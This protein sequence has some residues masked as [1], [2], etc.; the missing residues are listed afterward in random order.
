MDPNGASIG[1]ANVQITES[2]TGTVRSAETD[3][4]GSFNFTQVKP[5]VYSVVV[6]HDGF[7]KYQRDNVTVL[8]ASPTTVDVQLALGDIKETVTVESGAMPTLNT[9]DA[10]VGNPFDEKEVK[11][12]PFAAVQWSGWMPRWKQGSA[13][14]LPARA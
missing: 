7:R 8:V 5:G 4:N 3:G 12:L 2:G 9:L 13:V 6:T 14:A 11:G 10:T 1:K